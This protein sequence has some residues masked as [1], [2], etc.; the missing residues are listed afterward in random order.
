[1]SRLFKIGFVALFA[2]LATGCSIVAPKYSPS[3]PNVGQLKSAGDFNAKVGKF[4]SVDGSPGNANPISIRGSGMHSPYNNSYAEYLAAAIAQEL[5]LAGRLNPGSQLEISGL[6]QKNDLDG[7]G[8][9]TGTGDIQAR[10][11]V[12]KAGA[13]VYDQVKVAHIEWESSFAGAIAI[14]K[15]QQSYPDL[16]SKL[17]ETLYADN[18]FINALK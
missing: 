7:S 13:I 9:N 16:V 5:E 1:M 18:N 6:L 10:F 8:M 11:V 2:M 14:P 4:T 12:K 17:L 3:I 15:A